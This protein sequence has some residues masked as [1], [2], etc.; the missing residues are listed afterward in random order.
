MRNT[1]RLPQISREREIPI[2]FRF[3]DTTDSAQTGR[4]KTG[5]ECRFRTVRFE[6]RRRILQNYVNRNDTFRFAREL[7]QHRSVFLLRFV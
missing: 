1:R 7:H 6:K 3:A 4:V 2:R 5:Y